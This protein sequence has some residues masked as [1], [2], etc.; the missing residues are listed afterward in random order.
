MR[1]P[2]LSRRAYLLTGDHQLAEDLVQTALSRAY[3]RWSRIV[4][5]GDPEAYLRRIMI[6]ERTSWWRRRRYETVVSG[7]VGDLSDAVRGTPGADEADRVSQRV[8][9]L[10]AL[11]HLSPRQRAIVVLRYYEDL[12]VAETAELLGCSTGT[13][14]STTADA[15]AR[16][17]PLTADLKEVR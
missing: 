17:R 15:L 7:G 13:V 9:L 8:A 16:L 10:A 6:N 1:G 3:A 14:K 2:A 12:S 11:A 5:G 4:V